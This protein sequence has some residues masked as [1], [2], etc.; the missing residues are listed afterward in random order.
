LYTLLL[1]ASQACKPSSVLGDHLSR[2][3]VAMWLKR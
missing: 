2:P 1:I 3:Y